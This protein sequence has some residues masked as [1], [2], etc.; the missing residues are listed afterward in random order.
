MATRLQQTPGATSDEQQRWMTF[1]RATALHLAVWRGRSAAVEFLIGQGADIEL[2][3][4]AGM[5]ALQVDVMRICLQKMRPTL[6]LRSRCIDVQSPV[7]T[8][9]SKRRQVRD[10]FTYRDIDT[11]V[12]DLLLDHN[13]HVDQR[14]E[15]GDT[16]LLNAAEYGLIKHV[17]KLLAHGADASARD[18][19][20]R[21]AMDIAGEHGFADIVNALADS[22][23]RL[24]SSVGDKTLVMAGV[25][26][27]GDE[28]GSRLLNIAAEYDAPSCA[29]FLLQR[30]VSAR[31]TN[32]KGQNAVQVAC[33]RGHPEILEMLLQRSGPDESRSTDLANARNDATVLS[34][35]SI[36]I[37]V[38]QTCDSSVSFLDLDNSHHPFPVFVAVKMPANLEIME[39]LIR[40]SAKFDFPSRRSQDS[41]APLLA[42]WLLRVAPSEVSKLLVDLAS[43]GAIRHKQLR[44]VI[45]ALTWQKYT[46][47]ALLVALLVLFSPQAMEV[48]KAL[49]ILKPWMA[50]CEVNLVT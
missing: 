49:A 30:G 14:N 1:E 24:V 36:Q 8:A 44:H 46:H 28:L 25:T 47:E 15:S 19:R 38:L 29:L 39:V 35:P 40:H 23:P 22:C 21:S 41:I 42:S 48:E 32:A 3:D 6:L 9:M 12:L 45:L 33:A 27:G 2:Q 16:A 13:A 17:E 34:H 10:R 37:D 7:A 50:R 11:S 31:W 26:K 4:Q 18:Q 43:S 20:G 5:T